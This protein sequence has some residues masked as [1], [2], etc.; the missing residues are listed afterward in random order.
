M[1]LA[2]KK[3]EA[4][5]RAL[6]EYED[7]LRRSLSDVPRGSGDADNEFDHIK[8]SITQVKSAKRVLWI[9]E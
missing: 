8:A 2:T 5:R 7:E 3:R 1:H 9:E 6:N 4:V